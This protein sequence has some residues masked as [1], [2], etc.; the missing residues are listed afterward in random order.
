MYTI[1]E[2]VKYLKQKPKDSS[3]TKKPIKYMTFDKVVPKKK[4]K[5][6]YTPIEKKK[7]AETKISQDQDQTIRTDDI[8]PSDLKFPYNKEVSR[9][10]KK[11]DTAKSPT[12]RPLRSPQ[13]LSPNLILYKLMKKEEEAEKKN[14]NK[15]LHVKGT[16]TNMPY[17]TIFSEKNDPESYSLD[18]ETVQDTS[19]IKTLL[20]LPIEQ[21]LTCFTQPDIQKF[22]SLYLEPSDKL[23][24][25][26]GID[27]TRKEMVY[28]TQLYQRKFPFLS[29]Q[30]LKTKSTEFSNLLDGIKH[31]KGPSLEF[32]LTSLTNV[33]GNFKK[34][35]ALYG[36][37]EL[38]DWTNF[39]STHLSIKNQDLW[40]QLKHEKK[41]WQRTVFQDNESSVIV[42]YTEFRDYLKALATNLSINHEKIMTSFPQSPLLPILQSK[43]TAIEKFLKTQQST[44]ELVFPDTSKY[45]KP[46]HEIRL[47]HNYVVNRNE[48]SLNDMN[49]LEK[50]YKYHKSVLK[51]L[52]AHEDSLVLQRNYEKRMKYNQHVIQVTESPEE[53]YDQCFNN[54]G[55]YLSFI[56]PYIHASVTQTVYKHPRILFPVPVR[57]TSI[58]FIP[59]YFNNVDVTLLDGS[60]DIH[61][62]LETFEGD[63]L[64]SDYYIE[65]NWKN[66]QLIREGVLFSQCHQHDLVTDDCQKTIDRDSYYL[67]TRQIQSH[68]TF[69]Q[70][71]IKKLVKQA[72]FKEKSYP[73]ILEYVIMQLN[74]LQRRG[75]FKPKQ[76]VVQRPV[77]SQNFRYIDANGKRKYKSSLVHVTTEALTFM[78]NV[79]I[80]YPYFRKIDPHTGFIVPILM[81][82]D[83]M[84]SSAA[85]DEKTGFQ[86]FDVKD[87]IYTIKQVMMPLTDEERIQEQ[88]KRDKERNDIERITTH[89]NT[90]TEDTDPEIEEKI[91]EDDDTY[92]KR[93]CDETN[94]D[95]LIK[96][97]ITSVDEIPCIYFLC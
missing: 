76:E 91:N 77:Y 21:I 26:N 23:F 42:P 18:Y 6:Q 81:I 63:T 84:S 20:T 45:I 28:L 87:V 79:K 29:F 74:R 71:F 60:R 2:P 64:F 67:F 70:P 52:Y 37:I 1:K 9:P 75:M 31:K 44:L 4:S 43:L 22:Y 14:K 86:I 16:L 40:N 66:R 93:E 97:R 73:F 82:D 5:P 61:Y 90:K 8:D 49:A 53:L 54:N 15:K 50:R 47:F 35:N 24:Q 57:Y 25:Y 12:F 55:K 85:F 36:N 38:D 65:Y 95:D 17:V 27:F 59:V 78:K 48:E 83:L 13:S 3:I 56:R 19:L 96:F 33:P 11:Y 10:I 30:D 68:F 94:I 80:E 92:E 34:N 89:V 46:P 72:S 32:K 62:E 51:D 41:V 39:Y 7:E 69:V 58:Y 88:I